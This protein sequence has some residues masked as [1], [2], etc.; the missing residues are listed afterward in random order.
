MTTRDVYDRHMR[1]EL[2]GDLDTILSDY[3][4]DAIV[5]TPDGIG[6]GHDYIRP[7]YGRLL[8]LITST[9]MMSSIQVLGDVL[10][11]T[12]RAHRNGTDELIGSDTFVIRDDLI[13]MHTFY[14][15]SP[16]PT[17]DDQS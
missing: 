3:A 7:I 14:G 2:G 17:A 11:L 12:F 13:Q 10:Y 15:I 9:E 16:N 1:N 5:A 4:P 8:P 6:S